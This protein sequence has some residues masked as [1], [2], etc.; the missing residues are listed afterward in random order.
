[1]L[2]P[3]NPNWRGESENVEAAAEEAAEEY[4]T[5]HPCRVGIFSGAAIQQKIQVD[6]WEGHR[7]TFWR[8]RPVTTFSVSQIFEPMED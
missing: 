7:A 6:T 5:V 3:D 8:A 2:W 1:M 4:A